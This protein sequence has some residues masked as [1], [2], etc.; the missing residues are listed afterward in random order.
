[1]SAFFSQFKFYLIG[2]VGILIAL[3]AWWTLG[4]SGEDDALLATDT[5]AGGLVDKE[6]VGTLLQL[7]AV[8][9]NGT[10]FSDPAFIQ[11]QDFGTQ[12]IPEPVGRPNPFAPTSNRGA[13][14]TGNQLFPRR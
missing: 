12:I 7:R 4:A 5:P 10:I 11:L 14:T 1:M 13:T 9:L 3:S 6:V 2:G 8:T